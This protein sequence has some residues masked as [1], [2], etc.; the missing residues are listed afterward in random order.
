[1][2]YG[3]VNPKKYTVTETFELKNGKIW[4]HVFFVSLSLYFVDAKIAY[5]HACKQSA[6]ITACLKILE[7]I[8]K[9][10][11]LSY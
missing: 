10:N 2:F 8:L 11:K 1:M 6:Y 4:V 7:K 3:A 9:K 5:V